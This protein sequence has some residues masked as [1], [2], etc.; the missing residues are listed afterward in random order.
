MLS[1]NR[2]KMVTMLLI[3]ET[4]HFQMHIICKNMAFFG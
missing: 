3:K 1:Y 2:I 4:L